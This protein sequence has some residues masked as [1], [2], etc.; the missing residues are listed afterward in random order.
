MVIHVGMQSVHHTL[1]QCAELTTVVAAQPNGT[2]EQTKSHAEV[3]QLPSNDKLFKPRL[4]PRPYFLLL[5]WGGGG[6]G[7]MAGDKA[8][9]VHVDGVYSNRQISLSLSCIADSNTICFN[10]FP[11]TIGLVDCSDAI[12]DCPTPPYQCPPDSIIVSTRTDP[13]CVSYE[14]VCPNI[15]CPLLMECGQ[16]VQP[17]PDY[18]GNG[19]PGRCC[20]DYS[21]EGENNVAIV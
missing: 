13:C 12:C 2:L 14:C 19:F 4:V 18:R 16:G 10:Q 20:P 8:I 1:R 17:I 9:I 11:P 21:F 5:K 7:G 6:G 15:S 3:C